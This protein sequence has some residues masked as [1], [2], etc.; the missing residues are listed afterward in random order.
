MINFLSP[1]SSTSICK[2]LVKQ[3]LT[4]SLVLRCSLTHTISNYLRQHHGTINFSY[5]GFAIGSAPLDAV[6]LAFFFFCEVRG[7]AGGLSAGLTSSAIS[8]SCYATDNN[9]YHQ[10]LTMYVGEPVLEFHI[11]HTLWSNK[12][13]ALDHPTV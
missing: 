11:V 7:S 8:P 12:L 9:N 4:S 3:S 6:A 2:L 10:T 5:R 1:F 13:V